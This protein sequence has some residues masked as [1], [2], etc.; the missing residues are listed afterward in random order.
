MNTILASLPRLLVAILVLS[1]AQ[2]SFAFDVLVL[3]Q[4]AALCDRGNLNVFEAK[5][6]LIVGNS[7]IHLF[8][9][10]PKAKTAA[11]YIAVTLK[12]GKDADAEIPLFNK[13][14]VSDASLLATL[15]SNGDITFKSYMNQNVNIIFRRHDTDLKHTKWKVDPND[16]TSGAPSVWLVEYAAKATSHRPPNADDWCKNVPKHVDHPNI[17]D[18]SFAMCPYNPALAYEYEL[19]LEQKGADIVP[20]DIGIDPQIVHQP[21]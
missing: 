20:V 21:N 8:V 2:P 15:S 9:L 17:S 19:H 18:V 3:K 5:E 13:I 11:P 14:C 4:F 6:D 10:S 16:K 12:R 1:G 7:H